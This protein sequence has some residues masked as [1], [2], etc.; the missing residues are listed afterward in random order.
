MRCGITGLLRYLKKTALR[1][2]LVTI[3]CHTS[4][5]TRIIYSCPYRNCMYS[6][7]RLCVCACVG[8]LY[9]IQCTQDVHTLCT[10]S[11]GTHTNT[12]ML[13]AFYSLMNQMH[14]KSAFR[15]LSCAHIIFASRIKCV[16]IQNLYELDRICER[17]FFLFSTKAHIITL[18]KFLSF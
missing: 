3:K 18:V 5:F 4:S 11:R 8:S 17:L 1:N 13:R 2:V 6:H 16:P 14:F 7:M 12:H 10:P 15:K 9:F